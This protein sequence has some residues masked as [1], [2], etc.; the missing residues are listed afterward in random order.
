VSYLFDTDALSEVLRKRPSATYLAWL[1]TVPRTD[2][3]ASVISLAELYRGAYRSPARRRWLER[4]DRHLIRSVTFVAFDPETARIYG[5]IRA[6]LEAD[7]R[8]PGEGDL[9]IA[10]TA[11]HHGLTVV[12]GNIRHFERVPGLRLSHAFADRR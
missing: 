10:A 11:L 4:I 5:R 12:T 7:G 9:Q 8:L 1:Q 3:F 2:Q 6:H